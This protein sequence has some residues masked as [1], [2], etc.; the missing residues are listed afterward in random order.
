MEGATKKVVTII[1]SLIA[2]V[3]AGYLL[4]KLYNIAIA[5]ATARIKQGV[6]EGVEQ[7]VGKGVGNLNPLRG[8]GKLF[9][10]GK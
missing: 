8:I 9:G 2:I 3:I 6:E 1:G 4:Y 5:D 10:G 7:G